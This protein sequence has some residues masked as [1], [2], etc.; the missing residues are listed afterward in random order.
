MT[1]LA[2]N[3]ISRVC[4]ELTADVIQDCI[5]LCSHARHFANVVGDR[6]GCTHSQGRDGANTAPSTQIKHRPSVVHELGVPNNVV[7]DTPASGPN[8]AP[9][10]QPPPIGQA[11]GI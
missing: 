11:S 6:R 10:W 1:N 2:A 5:L 4:G 3:Q 8:K 7:R 9:P